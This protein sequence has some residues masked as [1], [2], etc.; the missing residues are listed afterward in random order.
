[1]RITLNDLSQEK[2]KTF[3]DCGLQL[4]KMELDEKECK[5]RLKQ[6]GI[7]LY[8]NI[9]IE[10]LNLDYTSKKLNLLIAFEKDGMDFDALKNFDEKTIEEIRLSAKRGLDITRLLNENYTSSQ[11]EEINNCYEEMF[12]N[13]NEDITLDN[14]LLK[15][16]LVKQEEVIDTSDI[17]ELM[18]EQIETAIPNPYVEILPEEQVENIEEELVEESTTEEQSK[19]EEIISEP[20]AEEYPTENEDI[21]EFDLSNLDMLGQELASIFDSKENFFD[22]I[23]DR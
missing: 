13:S 6:I 2:I 19:L 9:P 18:Q 8:Y 3:E 12:K 22:D 15:L 7:G 16:G 4:L 1:M 20:V 5:E 17:P 11:I 14:V 23:E 10:K 21:I